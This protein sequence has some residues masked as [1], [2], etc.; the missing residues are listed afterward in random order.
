[1]ERRHLVTG[2]TLLVLCGLLAIGLYIGSQSLFSPLPKSGP[3]AD[4]SPSCTPATINTGHRLTSRDVEVSV[5]NAG[6]RQGLAGHV[7]DALAKRGFG[8]GDVGN[9]PESTTVHS[10]QVRATKANDAAAR[11]VARQFGP[12]TLVTVSNRELGPGVDVIVGNGFSSLKKARHWI[13]VSG[14]QRICL[15]TS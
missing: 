13:R 2:I 11:L 3:I 6:N 4:P 14:K 1:M 10:V 5:F 12:R 7:Q 8:R 9:A 15:P